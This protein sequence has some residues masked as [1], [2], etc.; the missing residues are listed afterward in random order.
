[1]LQTIINVS[2]LLILF[3]FAV[4]WAFQAPPGR[5]TALWVAR[6]VGATLFGC[7]PPVIIFIRANSAADLGGPLFLPL[8]G[9]L[10]A[11]LG[12]FAGT[13]CCFVASKLAK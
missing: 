6:I 9:L 10:G 4:S 7:L 13:A 3:G 11:M 1:M 12:F 2:L 8:L 5:R